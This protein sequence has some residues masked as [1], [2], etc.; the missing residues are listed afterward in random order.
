METHPQDL[1]RITTEGKVFAKSNLQSPH[2]LFAVGRIS[3]LFDQD[4]AFHLLEKAAQNGSAPANA[5]MGYLLF[6][7][8]NLKPALSLMSKAW[9][10]GFKDPELE[11]LINETKES[12]LDPQEFNRPDLIQALFEKDM[13][14][15][16]SKGLITSWYIGA[17]Q[18]VFWSSDILFIIEDPKFFLELEPK[19]TTREGNLAQKVQE[20]TLGTI[21]K[22]LINYSIVEEGTQDAR[23]L[24]ILYETNPNAFRRV[25]SGMVSYTQN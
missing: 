11:I 12:I 14:Y 18:N 2:Y 8:G 16:K 25:Y 13:V 24:A 5:Y 15:L 6:D 22:G 23:R 3:Y 20:S 1:Y 4:S 17:M 19:I 21:G 9:K 7:E 10:N